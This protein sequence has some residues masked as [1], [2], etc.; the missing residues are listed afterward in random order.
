M[1][2]SPSEFFWIDQANPKSAN[3]IQQSEFINKLD[4]FRSQWT[5]SAEWRY[6]SALNN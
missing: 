1:G 4:G 2:I 5:K 6:L 3:L